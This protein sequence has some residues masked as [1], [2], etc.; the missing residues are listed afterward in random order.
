MS[1]LRGTPLRGGNTATPYRLMALS[2]W[3]FSTTTCN[4]VR[5]C[6]AQ[7]KQEVTSPSGRW[8]AVAFTR[9]CGALGSPQTGVSVLEPTSVQGGE[10]PNVLNLSYTPGMRP[11]DAAQVLENVSV[12]WSDDSS[13]TIRYDS[14]AAVLY[15]VTR[16][17][18]LTI[19]YS[20][21]SLP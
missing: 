9:S 2:L 14:R 10:Y 8:K 12:R 7:V 1:V 6:S 15:Q 20:N 16:V 19:H 18:G 3:L 13:I 4:N 21:D 17:W 5:A 11:E